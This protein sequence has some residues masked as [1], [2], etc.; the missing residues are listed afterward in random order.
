MAAPAPSGFQERLER[1]LAQLPDSPRE[2]IDRGAIDDVTRAQGEPDSLHRLVMDLH[3]L[4]NALQAELAEERLDGAAIRRVDDSDRP[5]IAAFMAGL[6]RTAPLKFNHPGLDTTVTRVGNRLIIQNDLG[7]TDAHVL[8]IHVEGSA[9][10][11]CIPT[12]IRS[13]SSSFARC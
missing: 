4:L 7:T 1:L 2:L 6:N 5:L 9:P 10:D 3:K 13:E 8:V 11:S 12:F